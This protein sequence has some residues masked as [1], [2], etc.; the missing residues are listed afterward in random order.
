MAE[1]TIAARAPKIMQLEPG[2][3]S[4][5]ACGRSQDQPFCDGSHQGSGFSP[6]TF[7]ITV[8]KSYALCLCKHT[9]KPP[10]CDGAHKKL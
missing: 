3:Y 10:F 4:W 2:S 7:D 8:K 6:K 1:P 5:C 9:A